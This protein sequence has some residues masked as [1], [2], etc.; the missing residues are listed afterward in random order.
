MRITQRPSAASAADDPG[1]SEFGGVDGGGDSII[2]GQFRRRRAPV[3]LMPQ[4]RL[5][6]GRARC[7]PG[8][9]L[10]G[11]RPRASEPPWP[12]SDLP[13]IHQQEPDRARRQL[14]ASSACAWSPPTGEHGGGVPHVASASTSAAPAV[15]RKLVWF[16]SPTAPG[17]SLGP[18]ATIA[19]P[20]P[21]LGDGRVDGHVARPYGCRCFS[22][23]RD[24]RSPGRGDLVEL[25]PERPTKP[26]VG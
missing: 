1:S 22:P 11:S 14:A 17:R 7:Q 12:G 21:G 25:E 16:S 3:R 4:P 9:G 6:T 15:R 26:A 23:I 8:S 2:G 5:S 24:G 13:G 19:Q 20:M 10:L 18:A